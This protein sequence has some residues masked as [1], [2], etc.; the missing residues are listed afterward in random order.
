MDAL[1]AYICAVRLDRYHDSAW[2][3]LGLLYEGCTLSK[4]ALI[5][6]TNALEILKP[7]TNPEILQKIQHHGKHIN[8]LQNSASGQKDGLSG[9]SS[10]LTGQQQLIPSIEAAWRLPIP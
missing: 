2:Y 9:P 5:A 10:T 3:N 6:F 8:E 7:S 1:Q 4:D